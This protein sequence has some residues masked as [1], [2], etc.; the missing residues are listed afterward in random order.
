MD[1]S[2]GCSVSD[3]WKRRK[4][5]QLRGR[6]GRL[7]LSFLSHDNVNRLPE[8][9]KRDGGGEREASS[10][11]T[12]RPT[13]SRQQSRHCCHVIKSS[14]QLVNIGIK[15][16][17]TPRIKNLPKCDKS[18]TPLRSFR[19]HTYIHTSNNPPPPR[20]H[21]GGAWAPDSAQLTPARHGVRLLTKTRELPYRSMRP[22]ERTTITLRTR[23]H[24]HVI[25]EVSPRS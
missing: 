4:N 18:N 9:R 20:T 24:S 7:T 2:I 14:K 19:I 25:R 17:S 13:K 16:G 6:G 10:R 15:K 23:T 21:T 8:I 1:G 12:P 5:T 3:E 11:E 22:H